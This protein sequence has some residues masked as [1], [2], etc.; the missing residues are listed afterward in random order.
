MDFSDDGNLVYI[1]AI[2]P[3]LSEMANSVILVYRTGYPAVASLYDVFHINGRYDDML[4]SATGSFGDYV[5][6]TMNSIFM[7]FRQYEDPILV[8]E[9]SFDDYKF[10]VTYSNEPEHSYKYFASV[11]VKIANF[12]EDI[13]INDSRLN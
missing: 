13:I 9:D 2:D 6:V 10:N 7:M 4:I 11:E 8:F 12:P 1:T 5:S 3:D